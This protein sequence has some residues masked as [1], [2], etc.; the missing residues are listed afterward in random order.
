M[1]VITQDVKSSNCA[2]TERQFGQQTPLYGDHTGSLIR[3]QT[4]ELIEHGGLVSKQKPILQYIPY[5]HSEFY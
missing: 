4:Y 2:V 3:E 1:T 5:S